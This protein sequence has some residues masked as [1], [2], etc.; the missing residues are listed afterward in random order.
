VSWATYAP[1]VKESAGNPKGSGSTGH[2]NRYLARVLG[3][4]A[5]AASKIDTFLGERYRQIA[6]RRGKQRA[7]LA[8][9]RSILV[10]VWHLLSDPEAHFHDLGAGLLPH[11]PA[12]GPRRQGHPGT[13]RLAGTMNAAWTRLRCAPPGAAACLLTVDFPVRT[14]SQVQVQP[15][16]LHRL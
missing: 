10:I 3:E 15:G 12:G 5:V 14:R 1:G 7:I 13:R 6:P 9:G 16:P 2:G 11:P 8:V 4:A